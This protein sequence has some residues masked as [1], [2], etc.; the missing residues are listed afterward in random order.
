MFSPKEAEFLRKCE[1]EN[2]RMDREY[3]KA[4]DAAGWVCLGLEFR[5]EAYRLK[6]ESF[7][8]YKAFLLEGGWQSFL[9]NHPKRRPL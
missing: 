9:D 2:A 8:K 5:D 6:K 1:N 4:R 3:N 7:K